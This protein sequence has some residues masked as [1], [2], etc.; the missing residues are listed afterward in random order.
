MR[1]L[2]GDA[3]SLKIGD[4]GFLG[5]W[6]RPA[7]ERQQR[8]GG[9]PGTPGRCGRTWLDTLIQIAHLSRPCLSQPE[10]TQRKELQ[11]CFCKEPL[12][13][14]ILIQ[15]EAGSFQSHSLYRVEDTRRTSLFWLKARCLHTVKSGSDST[16]GGEK[17]SARILGRKALSF[18]GLHSSSDFFFLSRFE[19]NVISTHKMDQAFYT[20]NNNLTSP[21]QLK[22]FTAQS[23]CERVNEC[24]RES[25]CV[26]RGLLV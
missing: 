17:K 4:Q 15:G 21:I 22:Y 25:V 7:K 11:K 2:L 1:S 13:V 23:L 12:F 10:L 8:S 19:R 14:C 9:Q 16:R 24:S 5:K 20:S 18:L 3:C 26:K 6:R